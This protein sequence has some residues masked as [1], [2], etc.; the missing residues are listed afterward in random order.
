M[1]SI[2]SMSNADKFFGHLN[3]VLQWN[4]VRCK[5]RE[6]L[7]K[8]FELGFNFNWQWFGP[9]RID[10]GVPQSDLH[11]SPIFKF[12]GGAYTAL[13]GWFP[14]QDWARK[15]TVTVEVVNLLD[16]R[17]HVRNATGRTPNR[18]QRDYLDPLGRTVKLTLRK[19]F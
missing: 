5:S 8:C 4:S 18:Y 11:F 16:R 13:G 6:F 17:Q 14:H 3:S 12:G 7:L 9:S 1:F 10:G 19:L 15:A 2:D